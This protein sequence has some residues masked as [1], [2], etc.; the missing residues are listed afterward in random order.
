MEKNGTKEKTAQLIL[1]YNA[2]RLS[3]ALC[4][5]SVLVFFRVVVVYD[6]EVSVKEKQQSLFS[7]AKTSVL[8]LFDDDENG[9]EE[10]AL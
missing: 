2:R 10:N 9:N 3:V 4:T 7:N 8:L 1:K 6:V 5:L